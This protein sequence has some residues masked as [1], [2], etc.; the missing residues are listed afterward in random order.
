MASEISTR[1][2]E[3]LNTTNFQMWKFQLENLFIAQGI[4]DIVDGTRERPTQGGVELKS[5]LKDDAKAKFLISSAMEPE[6]VRHILIC[7]SSKEM[8]TK[9]KA[10]HAQCSSTHKL[11]LTQR[12]HEY[13]MSATD[14][15]ATHIAKV[16]NM[17][18][19]LLDVGENVSDLTITA[20]IL[21]SLPSKYKGFRSAWNSVEPSRQT[22]EY[23]QQR[24][25]EK[26]SFLEGDIEEEAKA[27]AATVKK[28]GKADGGSGAHRKKGSK[29]QH[30][31]NVKSEVQKADFLTKP[32]PNDRFHFMCESLNICEVE[33]SD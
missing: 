22:V 13:R 11:L 27:L 6:Q 4:E 28:G 12:F 31:K 17:A 9:L 2:I 23:L 21:A 29:Q 26:E 10:I 16:Q 18:R 15:V 25:L 20:K 1:H 3:K 7:E 8:W 19:Q 5:W 32:L 30:R 33:F 24:L 14:S